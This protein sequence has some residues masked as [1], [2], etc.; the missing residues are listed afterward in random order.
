VAAPAAGPQALAIIRVFNFIFREI[1]D[2]VAK[3]GMDRQ[4]IAAA[5]AALAGQALSASPVL[6]GMFFDAEGS[7][8]EG[9]LLRRFEFSKER[10]GS[11][12][13]A[14]LRQALSD[15][16]FFLLFQV[17]ELLESHADEDLARRVKELLGTLEAEFP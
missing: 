11:E 15:V 13:L 5:N 7:L 2:E 3:K 4:F 17:G 6:T 10:L 14:S 16:M 12:P 9:K 8:D 1:R